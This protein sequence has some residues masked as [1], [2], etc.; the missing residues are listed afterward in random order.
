M[1][2]IFKE[3]DVNSDGIVT[4]VEFKTAGFAWMKEQIKEHRAKAK[5]KAKEKS[6]E[7]K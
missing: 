2:P 3:W 7:K 1:E 6:K 5:E 4:I